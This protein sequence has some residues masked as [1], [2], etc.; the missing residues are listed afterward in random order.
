MGRLITAKVA[1]SH[2]LLKGWD[3]QSSEGKEGLWINVHT[4]YNQLSP[5]CCVWN[6]SFQAQ[7]C[8]V[9][10]LLWVVT[11]VVIA[12]LGEHNV[13]QGRLWPG[14]VQIKHVSSRKFW[15]V[16]RVYL[17]IT[18]VSAK[19]RSSTVLILMIP[20]IQTV[21]FDH[22]LCVLDHKTSWSGLGKWQIV[23][24]LAGYSWW[25]LDLHPESTYLT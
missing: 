8:K 18:E 15:Y 11:S 10:S 4:C 14:K 19:P 7:C 1:I 9:I 22:N 2:Q 21:P 12:I 23:L 17:S 13:K 3:I 5:M 20:K 24:R 6:K 25:R 16:W